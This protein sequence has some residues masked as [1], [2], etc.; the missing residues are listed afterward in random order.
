ML[1]LPH[2]C[3]GS[4]YVDRRCPH[5]SLQRRGNMVVV[6]NAVLAVLEGQRK[7][8]YNTETCSV[9]GNIWSKLLLTYF[10]AFKAIEP[11]GGWQWR[12]KEWAWG[13]WCC[14][15]QS[16]NLQGNLPTHCGGYRFGEGWIN[17][18]CGTYLQVSQTCANPYMSWMSWMEAGV[19]IVYF[20]SYIVHYVTVAG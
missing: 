11:D 1:F 16:F 12:S 10:H 7:E 14:F 17:L 19:I 9:K 2:T 15:K 5:P 3:C 4:F 20:Y 13:Q 8:I 18:T 6:V